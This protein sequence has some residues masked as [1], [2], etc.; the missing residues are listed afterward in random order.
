MS[1]RAISRQVKL[2]KSTVK[3]ICTRYFSTGAV[4]CMPHTGRPKMTSCREDRALV[5]TCLKNRLLTAPLLKQVWDTSSTP[6]TTTV[7]RRL[8]SA[9]L[10]GRI[11]RR[12]PLLSPKHRQ[13]RLEFAKG[14]INWSANEWRKVVWSDESKFNIFNS[15]GR[16]YVRRRVGEELMDECG[17]SEAWWR[18]CDGVGLYV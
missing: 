10:N 2:P 8:R 5:R 1:F 11:A 14:H 12:K 15:D 3:D 13:A 6:S 4:E 16:T 9:G 17:N 18:E 7:K